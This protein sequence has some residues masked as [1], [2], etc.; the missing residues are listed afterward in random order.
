MRIYSCYAAAIII[1]FPSVASLAFQPQ[2]DKNPPA[3]SARESLMESRQGQPGLP[4]IVAHRQVTK[5]THLKCV[6]IEHN[7]KQAGD[8]PGCLL[9]FED[10]DRRMLSFGEWFR[11]PKNGELYL[12]CA[13][14]RPTRCTVVLW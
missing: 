14:D 5:D 4:D 8:R 1:T 10:G 6:K 7:P 9:R 11:S 3:R 13:G 2:A 12:E